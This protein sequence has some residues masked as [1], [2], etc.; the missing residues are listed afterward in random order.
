MLLGGGQLDGA[1]VLRPETVAELA[2]N[3]LGGLTVGPLRSLALDTTNDV[4]F[5]PGMVK[6]WGLGGLINTERAPT[7]RSAGSWGWA[8]LHNTYFWVDP[9]RRV[10][11]LLLTQLLPFC[12]EAVLDLYGRFEHAV[13]APGGEGVSATLKSAS[14]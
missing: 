10:A 11:G 13:Y 3:Q 14:S 1:R 4:E 12:D 7:G 5:F 6:K 8:G 9:T 2:R